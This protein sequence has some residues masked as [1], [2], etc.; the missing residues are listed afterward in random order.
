MNNFSGIWSK[1][2]ETKHDPFSKFGPK[3]TSGNRPWQP[4]G[5]EKHRDMMEET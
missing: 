3:I 4:T 5:A 1:A 2:N